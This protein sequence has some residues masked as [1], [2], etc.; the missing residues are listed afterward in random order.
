MIDR[1]DVLP[2]KRQCEILKLSRSGIY[3]TPVPVSARDMVLMKDMDGY[4]GQGTHQGKRCSGRTPMETFYDGIRLFQEKNLK[5][6]AA[7]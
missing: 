7:A 4:N 3:Y 1:E 5:D 2:L 6:M